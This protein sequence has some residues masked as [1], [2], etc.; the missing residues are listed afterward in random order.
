MLKNSDLI[1]FNKKAIY[2]ILLFAFSS[3]NLSN[4]VVII[5]HG[6][7]SSSSSWHSTEGAFFKNLEKTANL[8]DQT[9]VTF[10]WSG[11]PTKNEI[12]KA[13]KMLAKLISSYP[14]NEHI[15]LIGHSHGGNVINIASQNLLDIGAEILDNV[16]TITEENLEKEMFN[17]CDMPINENHEFVGLDL[18]TTS[19]NI[20]SSQQ[21]P[22]TYKIDCVYQ[23]GTPIDK[24]QY[25]PQMKVIKHIFNFYSRGDGV[26]KIAGFYKQHYPSHERI[27]NIE[28]KI[29]DLKKKKNYKPSH[30]GIHHP[31]VASWLLLVPFT[32]QE[33]KIG[34]FQNFEYGKDC[35]IVFKEKD[36]PIYLL[37]Q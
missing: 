23:L 31:A 3:V 24:K 15:T 35:T 9:L 6:A 10:N 4:A 37:K 14:K 25:A 26:Q 27:T 11:S 20:K 34:G 33:E 30:H 13:G 29:T 22:K 17:T 19:R 12:K 2:L 1:G 28:L 16:S 32:L 18:T 21:S 8:M 5:V 36:V 7:F